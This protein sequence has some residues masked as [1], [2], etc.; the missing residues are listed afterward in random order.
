MSNCIYSSICEYHV[1]FIVK[2]LITNPLQIFYTI[3]LWPLLLKLAKMNL[4]L[5]LMASA[6]KFCNS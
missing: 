6:I 5:L 2:H 1:K 4:L 3:Y